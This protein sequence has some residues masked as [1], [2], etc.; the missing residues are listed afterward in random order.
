MIRPLG[1]L[2]LF[3]T[4]AFSHA[5]VGEIHNDPWK[6]LGIPHP[7]NVLIIVSFISGLFVFYAIFVKTLSDRVKKIVYFFIAVP[8]VIGTIYLAAT[9]VYLNLV[10]ET[11]GPVHWHADYEVWGCGEKYELADPSGFENRVGT[12]VLHE[13]NDNRIHVEGVL[14]KKAEASLGNYFDQVGGNLE[15]DL[16]TIPTTKGLLT[17]KNGDKCNGQPGKW[18]VFVNG[19]LIADPENYIISPYTLVPP[20]DQIKLVFTDKRSDQIN[21]QI[22]GPP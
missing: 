3:L 21:T 17:W 20:G 9:T 8:I 4:L 6:V 5:D 11:G 22:G 16:L 15:S 10:S 14:L 13:H 7:T 12:P 1:I 19:K 18:Y 2:L